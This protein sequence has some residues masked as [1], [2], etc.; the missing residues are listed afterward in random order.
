MVAI[1]AGLILGSPLLLLGERLLAERLRGTDTGRP[2]AWAIAAVVLLVTGLIAS[3]VPAT[4]AARLD[5]RRSIDA[6]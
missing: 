5:P 4:R 6:T 1:A 2:D 3:S